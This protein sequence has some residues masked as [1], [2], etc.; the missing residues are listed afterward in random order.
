MFTNTKNSK[1]QGDVGL[2]AAIFYF[3]KKG[4]TVSIPLTDSQDYDL[5]VDIDNKLCRVQAKTSSFKTKYGRYSVGL[6]TLG[7]NTSWN[8]VVKYFDNTKTEYLFVLTENNE[9]YL[10]PSYEIKNKSS[11]NVGKNKYDKFKIRLDWCN[12]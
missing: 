11:I 4:H 8:G 7:G 6:R 5:I 3:S 12:K 10:I 2:S 9:A 1:K